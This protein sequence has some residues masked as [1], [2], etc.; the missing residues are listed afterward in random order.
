M[1]GRRKSDKALKPIVVKLDDGSVVRCTLTS[2]G[3]E[4]QPR[5]ILMGADGVQY[6]G[7]EAASDKSPEAV[8]R[9]VSEWWATKKPGK[10]APA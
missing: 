1:K 7:P 8:Q 6:V 9:L 2:I 4:A 3:R 5:W 10:G